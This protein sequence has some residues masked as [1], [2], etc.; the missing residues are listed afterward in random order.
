MVNLKSMII[1]LGMRIEHYQFWKII[2][3]FEWGTKTTDYKLLSTKLKSGN[4]NWRTIYEIFSEYKA[5]LKN[6]ICI[7]ETENNKSLGVGD[8][9]FDDLTSHIIGLGKKEY[10]N[11]MANPE[12]AYIR[13]GKKYGSPEGFKESFAYI[14][15]DLW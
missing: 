7:W 13:A 10:D 5:R 6:K 4:Y 15:N 8:D 2:E 9:S 1:G 12:L 11:V 14:F 3:E